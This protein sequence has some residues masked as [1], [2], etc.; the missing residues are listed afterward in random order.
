[1]ALAVRFTGNVA[2]RLKKASEETPYKMMALALYF[3]IYE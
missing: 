3:L 2:H 1:M